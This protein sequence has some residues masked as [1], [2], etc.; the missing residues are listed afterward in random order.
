[1]HTTGTGLGIQFL[2]PLVWVVQNPG[3]QE[4]ETRNQIRS[5]H[6]SVNFWS[7]IGADLGV[8]NYHRYMD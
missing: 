2:M 6:Y 3:H 4:P 8:R 5:E 7:H 1:M